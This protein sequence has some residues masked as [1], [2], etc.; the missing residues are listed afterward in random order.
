MVNTNAQAFACTVTQMVA[1][2][3]DHVRPLQCES[4][5]RDSP[6]EHVSQVANTQAK[7]ATPLALE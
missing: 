6:T 2:S 5:S 1:D 4:L 7:E 3:N